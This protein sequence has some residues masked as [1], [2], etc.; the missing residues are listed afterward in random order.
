MNKKKT[1]EI[2][3]F[4]KWLEREIGAEI[5]SLTNKTAIKEYPEHDF[6]Q[7]IELLKKN[8]NKISIDPSD[9]KT[10]ELL[11]NQFAKSMSLLSNL[12]VRIETT[13]EFIDIFSL[14]R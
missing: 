11:E 14:Q 5:D 9:R 13:G 12:K 3:V 10:Q 4:L 6:N 8:R 7:F 2:K 1:D